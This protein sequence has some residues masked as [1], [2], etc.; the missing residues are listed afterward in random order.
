MAELQ[1][2]FPDELALYV[3]G[4]GA[5][6]GEKMETKGGWRVGFGMEESEEAGELGDTRDGRVALSAGS[7]RR[8]LLLQLL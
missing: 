1:A 3:L 8:Q 5:E 2:L 6:D 4:G 7:K